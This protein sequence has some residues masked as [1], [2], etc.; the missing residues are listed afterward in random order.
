M[1]RIIGLFVFL[2][3]FLPL[4]ANSGLKLD[5]LAIVE[6]FTVFGTTVGDAATVVSD[7]AVTAKQIVQKGTQLKAYVEKTKLMVD[8][9]FKKIEETVPGYD[10]KDD[11][12]YEEE[13]AAA[14][15]K[16]DGT[17][18][19]LKRDEAAIEGDL[20]TRKE[21]LITEY[22]G[23]KATIEENISI[24]NQMLKD[25]EDE[26]TRR[27]IQTQI[28]SLSAEVKSYDDSINDLQSEDSEILENDPEYQKMMARKAEIKQK[29]KGYAIL[30]GGML[31]KFTASAIKNMLQKDDATKTQEYNAV[32]EANF[33]TPEEPEIS[34]NVDKK[35]KHRTE[36]LI[37]SMAVAI[38]T[39]AKFKNNYDK[40]IEEHHRIQNN[41]VGADQ[42]MSSLG[43][44]TQQT[45][46]ETEVLHEYN[47]L[48]IIDM[49]LRTAINM[50]NQ[51][52]RLKNYEKDP[53]TLNMDN[54]VF[55]EKDVKSDKSKKSFLDG[56]RAK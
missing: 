11:E 14:Q 44:Q 39:A 12:T 16:L 3:V 28:D 26:E 18:P 40:T 56:V 32:I 34:E 48:L 37:D 10:G 52:F 31:A 2:L 41:L 9:V 4:N 1:K 6:R 45:I 53:A 23:K 49:K 19:Q 51:D 17:E 20:E 29:L 22:N 21:A 54:Y 43:M 36:E 7:T 38:S 33:L 15:A 42:Q 8:D 47:K 5:G 35:R 46:L 24:L 55:T 25:A 13:E 27:S 50:K 30:A